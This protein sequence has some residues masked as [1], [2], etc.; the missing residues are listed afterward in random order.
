VHA[1]VSMGMLEKSSIS[2]MTKP[3][4]SIVIPVYNAGE[5][6]RPSVESI[7]SQT[8]SNLEILIIDDGSTDG[9]MDSVACLSDPRVHIMTQ[10]NLGRAVTLNRAL[11]KLS[12]TFY[13]THDADDI[14][15]LRRIELQV[16]CM[17]ANPNLAAVFTGHD[18]ILGRRRLAPRFSAK[19]VQ[20]C[21]RD[22]E[23]FRMPAHDPTGMFRVAMVRNI[24][25]E[26]TLKIGAGLDYILRVGELYPMMV[27]GKCLYSYRVH[28]GSTTRQNPSR[29]KLMVRRVLKRACERRGLDLIEYLSSEA[30]PISAF[31]HRER[32]GIVPHCMESVLD[33]RCA[34]QN[35]QALK[36][37]LACLQLHPCDPYYY[38][39]LA[40]FVAPLAFIRSYRSIKAKVTHF[41]RFCLR[42]WLRPR[43]K[44]STAFHKYA[45]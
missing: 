35:W 2:P 42:R 24:Y 38:K 33:L 1:S 12:G 23:Q 32:E 15:N 16:Q 13:A 19:T 43:S 27:L 28:F 36:T 34:G 26:P 37:T 11:E 45:D 18:I 8:Y 9:C 10:N 6:L 14:S 44:P 39:P 29:R 40:Y 30:T 25:Y 31:K 7:L 4:V 20:Q 3:L 41:R 17:L 22:V 21:S 5:Y